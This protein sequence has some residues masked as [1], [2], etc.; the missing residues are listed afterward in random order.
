MGLLKPGTLCAQEMSLNG[1]H[2]PP[3]PLLEAL[4]SPASEVTVPEEGGG[5]ALAISR[6]SA[7]PSS[8]VRTSLKG[9]L[10]FSFPALSGC[11]TGLSAL[12]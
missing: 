2:P 3:G 4:Q 8:H 9:K 7:G 12:G 1:F 11:G 10:A 6:V 5:V